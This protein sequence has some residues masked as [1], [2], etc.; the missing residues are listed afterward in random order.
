MPAGSPAGLERLGG[1][2][3]RQHLHMD[4]LGEDA[5]VVA[6]KRPGNV[7]ERD[8][9][10]EQLA[11]TLALLIQP[12]QAVTR[13]QPAGNVAL[14]ALLEPLSRLDFQGNADQAMVARCRVR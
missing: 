7:V 5:A 8:E 11:Q 10:V 9:L 1:I 4:Q 3:R 2:L 6:L 13:R 12:R 14:D